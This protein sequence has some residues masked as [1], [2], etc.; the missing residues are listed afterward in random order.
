MG[1][2]IGKSATCKPKKPYPD[3]PLYPHNSKRWAKKIDGKTVCFGSWDDPNG[4]L[5]KF[6][7]YVSVGGQMETKTAP[8]ATKPPKPY[9]DFPLYAHNTKR[10][11]KKIK[12]R[13]HFFGHW[14]DWKAALERFQYENDYLQQGKTPPPQN[15]D[16]LTVGDLVNGFL[17]NRESKV[18]S[19]EL[20]QRTWADSKRTG[21]FLIATLGRY[22]TVESLTPNDFEKLRVEISK[23][24]GLVQLGSQIIR[25][26]VFF[27]YAYK[28]EQIEK[29][30]R[31]GLSFQK[32]NKKSL[33]K[34]RL[35]KAAKV[36]TVDELTTIYKAAGQQMRCFMLLALN[37][38]LGN[39]DIGQME[40]KHI[41]NGWVRFPRPKTLVD[42]EFPLW[43]ESLKAI[44]ETRQTQYDSDL[45]FVTKYGMPWYKDSPDSPLGKEFSKL[46][47][48]CGLHSLGRGFYALRHTFR[49]VADGCRDRV[50]IDRIMGHS[51]DS[52]G[53]NY[54]EWIEPERLQAVVDHVR[55]WALPMLSVKGGAK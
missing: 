55:K 21:E 28:S 1:D 32:P 39:G 8:T 3:F 40:A 13:T 52:M 25:I 14:N 15:V 27:N 48:E 20:S 53:A 36:F 2:S 16:A 35:S 17:E 30:V 34:E 9:Q 41:Q 43:P 10:W 6:E 44:E 45:V 23:R 29:P 31:F 5:A 11:A 19:G 49:T 37:G 51:D 22:T 47:K 7:A 4:A 42:R 54:R 12:G 18:V 33:K 46:L 26:R 38:G 24:G 50:A